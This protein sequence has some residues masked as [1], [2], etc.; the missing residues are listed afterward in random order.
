MPVSPQGCALFDTA[1]GP[2][3]IAWGPDGLRGLRLPEESPDRTLSRIRDETGLDAADP[4][5]EAADAMARIASHLAGS[6]ADLAPIRLDFSGIPAFHRRVY[7]AARR[8][9]PGAT[10]NYA[11]LA[12]KAG[13]P[14]AA[15]AVGQAMARN[16]FPVVVPCHRV[17]A[18][19]GT[20][21]GFSAHGGLCTKELL[22]KI[23]GVSWRAKCRPADPAAACRRHR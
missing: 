14:G 17:L 22:L 8:V 16:P 1:I 4:T 21:G 3:A 13:S 23:E 9:P 15:R 18:K 7:E 6:E 10:T 19:G 12:E 2:C 5:P 11:D 20:P